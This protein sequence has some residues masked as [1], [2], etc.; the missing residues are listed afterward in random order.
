MIPEALASMKSHQ[1]NSQMLILATDRIRKRTLSKLLFV[2][3]GLGIGFSLIEIVSRCVYTKPWHE[4]L[5]ATQRRGRHAIPRNALG[6][7]GPAWMTPKPPGT[8]RILLLGDSFTFGQGV[9]D[10]DTIFSAILER[11]LTLEVA[12]NGQS[13]EILNG[14]LPGSLT[15]EWV[16][17]LDTLKDRFQP[18]LVV[19]IFFLRD[20]TRTSSMG[21]FFGPIR[22]EIVATNRNSVLYELSYAYR[23][24]K[25]RLDSDRIQKSYTRVLLDSYLGTQE[26]TTEWRIA[27]DN[28]RR[29]KAV[30]EA[31]GAQAALVIFPVLVELNSH[32]PFQEICDVIEAFGAKEDLPTDSLLPAFLNKNAPDLWVSPFDQHPN[33]KAHAI[34]AQSLLP[35]F[36]ALLQGRR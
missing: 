21:S 29:I 28:M 17:L 6:L 33:G 5:L 1:K 16:D 20:G 10:Y 22:N 30:A 35:F 36:R 11:R 13:V 25:N 19:M 8:K 14:G 26:Q 9:P 3:F 18:D 2:V 23:L 15:N 7:R 12:I 24:Y 4:E 34:A 27:Q 31:G 32:Y